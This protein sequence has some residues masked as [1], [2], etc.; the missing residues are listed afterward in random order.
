[1]E[2]T[3]VFCLEKF[4]CKFAVFKDQKE[5]F[6]WRERRRDLQES[7]FIYI[8]FKKRFKFSQVNWSI[9]QLNFKN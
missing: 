5:P 6:P 9:Y 8:N 3:S 1:M 7:V 2:L 4:Y